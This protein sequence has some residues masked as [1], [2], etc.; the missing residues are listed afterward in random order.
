MVELTAQLY[1]QMAESER[2]AEVVRRNLE[3]VGYG[4]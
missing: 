3:A 2:L 4:E 1:E